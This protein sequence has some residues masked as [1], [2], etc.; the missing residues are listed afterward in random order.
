MSEEAVVS[1]IRTALVNQEFRE[2]LF[3][4][5]EMALSSY[6]L[7][8]EERKSLSTMQEEAFDSLASELEERISKAG[9]GLKVPGRI[10]K[11][12]RSGVRFNDL[13]GL[14]GN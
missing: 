14:L 7:S 6:D 3:S 4:D 9:I 2:Q 11:R 8:E 5:P 13:K 10:E 1:V 12:I